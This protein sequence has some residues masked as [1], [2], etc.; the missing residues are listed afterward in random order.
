MAQ[1]N[2]AHPLQAAGSG[3]APAA[4]VLVDR[5]DGDGARRGAKFS[6]DGSE[7]KIEDASLG[8]LHKGDHSDHQSIT[9]RAGQ[10]RPGSSTAVGPTSTESL[11]SVGARDSEGVSHDSTLDVA[12]ADDTSLL[13]GISA[14]DLNGVQAGNSSGFA[15]IY[16]HTARALASLAGSAAAGVSTLLHRVL[17]SDVNGV[18]ARAAPVL[19]SS[20]DTGDVPH[21]P[22]I[23]PTD[24]VPT[25]PDDSEGLT[26]G[27][28]PTLPTNNG[29]ATPG[30]GATVPDI[31]P[32]FPGEEI[33]VPVV[34]AP[35]D[36]APNPPT[37]SLPTIEP[38]VGGGVTTP[39]DTAPEPP[40]NSAPSTPGDGATV[41]D[42]MPGFPG[43]EI[44]VPVVPVPIDVVPN[45]P[46]DSSP[47]I[48]PPAGGGVTTPVDVPPE[49]PSEI[50]TPV[51][52]PP[53]EAVPIPS[54]GIAPLPEVELT[55]RED[56]DVTL[57]VD[58]TPD[59]PAEGIESPSGCLPDEGPSAP[60]DVLPVVENLLL[61]A[62][63]LSVSIATGF[64]N[65]AIP[66]D[67]VAVGLQA[68]G[69][70]TL[71]VTIA[72]LPEDAI[73]SAG[74]ANSDGTWTLSGDELVGLTL[75]PAPDASDD[76]TLVVTATLQDT[77]TGATASAVVDL[78]VDI[79]AALPPAGETQAVELPALTAPAIEVSAAVGAE[80]TDIPLTISVGLLDL[81]VS[82]ELMITVSGLPTGASLS[83]GVVNTDGSWTLTR[84][85]LVELS[86][87]PAPDSDEDFTLA[88][89][90][91]VR[92][93]V[94]GAE[95]HVSATLPVEV[96]EAIGA[97]V[98]TPMLQAPSLAISA[99]VGIEN[100][101]VALSIATSLPDTSSATIL[102]VTI[103]GL[104]A[105]ANLSAGVQNA[106]G[107]WTLNGDELAGLTLSPA[108]D[109]DEDFTLN[110]TAT[111]RD[112]V[113]GLEAS[114]KV[115]LPVEIVDTSPAM[116][117]PV[118]AAPS[119]SVDAAAG[120][121]NGVI[122]L[123]ISA[124]IADVS[125][126]IDLTVVISGFPNGATLSA[127]RQGVDGT[128][129]LTSDQ[130]A[131]LTLTPAPDSGEDFTLT[132]VATARD[133]LTGIE[134]RTA[135]DLAVE[136]VDIE[137]PVLKIPAIAAPTLSVSAA[138]GAENG[139]IPLSISTGL[140]EVDAAASLTVVISGLPEGATL[141]TG[142]ANP[143]GSW[144]L[145]GDELAGL[146]LMPAPDS[147]E[148]FTLTVT[149]TARDAITGEE[150]RVTATLPVDV[151]ETSVP[152]E[153]KT[154]SVEIPAVTAPT[155]SVSAVVGIENE[156]VPLTISAALGEGRATSSLTVSI[157]GLP[158]GAVLS[159]GTQDADGTWLLDGG[160]L[161]GLTL[162]PAP[163]SDEDFTL[164]VTAT[165]RD[166]LTGL[167]ASTQ[168]T[169]P[170]EII[171][172]IVTS[173]EPTT[174]GE[175]P[176]ITA[177][178]LSVSAAA[179]LE[180]GTIPLAITVGAINAGAELEV[181][182]SGLPVGAAL[183][184]GVANA[185]GSWTVASDDLAGLTLTPAPD[186]GED[187]T[188]SVS[189]T[190]RDATSGIEA[191]TTAT[192]PVEVIDAIALTDPAPLFMLPIA[193]ALSVSAAMW[194][195]N[196]SIPLVI[197]VEVPSVT[198]STTL[199]V[200]VAGLPEGAT[201]SAGEQNADGTWNLSGDQLAGLTLTPAPNSSDDFAFS[202]TAT[203]YDALTGVAISTSAELTVD[204]IEALPPE[205]PS[206]MAPTL[207]VSVATG[208]ENGAIPLSIT[209]GLIDAASASTLT[210]TISG[211][212]EGATISAGTQSDDGTW[213][214]TGEEL[215]GL[216]LIPAA[217][218]DEDFT[219]SVGATV[220]DTFTGVE[221]TTSTTLAVEVLEAA[222]PAELPVIA[223]SQIEAPSLTI[224]AAAGVG[225]E[226]IP[227]TITASVA[228]LGSSDS[229][230]VAISGLPEGA[231]LSAGAQASDGTWLLDCGELAGLTLTPA[232]DSGEDFTLTVTAIVRDGLTG[233]QASTTATLPV[234]VIDAATPLSDAPA[235]QTPIV[236]PMLSV[237]AAVGAESDTIP[238]AISMGVFDAATGTLEITVSGLP[239]GATLS[240]GTP[241]ADGSWSLAGDDLAGLTLTPAPDSGEDFA[242]TVTATVRD[243]VTGTQASATAML[244]VE[245][246]DVV[247]PGEIAP[248]LGAPALMPTLSVSS[249]IGTADSE[250]P[251]AIALGPIAESA[252]GHLSALI[253]GVPEGATLSAGV[254]TPNG[255]WL[256]NGD[257]LAGLTLTPESGSTA[258]L[259]LIV[260]ATL[261]D[262]VTGT[263]ASAVAGLPVEIVDIAPQLAE[264]PPLVAPSLSVS[265]GIGV[266]NKAQP[267]II[268]ASSPDAIDPG[269]LTI[270]IGG[271]PET[272]VLSAG[273]ANAD[274]TWTL[275]AE[276]ISGLTLTPGSD[277]D[278]ILT[279]T[280]TVRD[281][282]TGL[283]AS[284]STMLAVDVADNFVAPDATSSLESPVLNEGIA[285]D[286]SLQATADTGTDVTGVVAAEAT[287]DTSS[288]SGITEV[289]GSSPLIETSEGGAIVESGALQTSDLPIEA[290]VAPLD[291][292]AA[293]DSLDA[294]MSDAEFL[295]A[296]ESLNGADSLLD[297]TQDAALTTSDALTSN[298]TAPAEGDPALVAE[299]IWGAEITTTT[300]PTVADE[301]V[302]P[303][304][305][306]T[307]VSVV[308]FHPGL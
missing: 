287:V 38:P 80:N 7:Q 21:P 200:T 264:L 168:V 109:S 166:A 262:P 302:A 263:E 16:Q 196:G 31:L 35:I 266:A 250:I 210:I 219:L 70:M 65:T 87:S 18:R 298:T 107:T 295:Q 29:A 252:G 55:L 202:V 43:E 158:I 286:T 45:P 271:M 95:A 283:E 46:T 277:A 137:A 199:T 63:T 289:T 9:H 33:E 91:S 232:A 292:T 208:L 192:L 267:L 58:T 249:A 223:P 261:I 51:V 230:T 2:K 24:A 108:P 260:T 227:L 299:D 5:Q 239:E 106:D 136:I 53:L 213:V 160:N 170:V 164:T 120:S 37:D 139:A 212:P 253:V 209:A 77:I 279:V 278:F 214:L 99:A 281:A 195:E 140:S 207:S 254:G 50:E 204:V 52:E 42:I 119:L 187:F 215:V 74:V 82:Q 156:T 155:L 183:S 221:A 123:V 275:T 133:R 145:S 206:L 305:E 257:E 241:N 197:L 62:P 235:T 231:T 90:A 83:A 224:S 25:P 71:N 6:G 307:L 129:L 15:S 118:F 101:T 280:A 180:D 189:A 40:T 244:P 138:V 4:N 222:P 301:P 242:L 93:L 96:I 76:F 191:T 291:T 144:S 229:L 270:M 179:G 259:T 54:T 64:E 185:D 186:S 56:N 68:A 238:L 105:G 86:L 255:T 181:T 132:V 182:I 190:I 243:A 17:D 36:V 127:G 188:L 153:T 184:A 171:D 126:A 293:T 159:A 113:T 169:L 304:P 97:P 12:L 149:A 217:D 49:L 88:V 104:P 59:L 268:T 85:D 112:G 152:I 225:N 79:I 30:D 308:V 28:G 177:P 19:P 273:T 248:D 161:A 233:A 303:P 173:L 246:V 39:V 272:A 237:S 34:P 201:L 125:G 1:Q 220:R 114:S 102:T 157:S 94:T 60:V 290:V 13:G 165:V 276:E 20:D 47:A 110:V 98:E 154:P 111:V 72:G 178:S 151:V 288:G 175:F 69:P 198:S 282:L 67:I 27:A 92:D 22:P 11:A 78:P 103:D 167:Q 147:D 143:D 84:S 81:D 10:A 8:H 226:A 296:I 130:L 256:L 26:P 176:P 300:E 124:G 245:V 247:A 163:D 174:G 23:L 236:A 284:S 162:T 251:L 116:E 73:L 14:Y 205:L 228:E 117:L 274:G 41:P 75:T 57:P 66:L 218:S 265:A 32:G 146:T 297:A 306:E 234:E 172:G 193:P 115:E 150:A 148:D 285:V 216:N 100:G 121:E 294:D 240:A 142:V 211:L 122:P 194:Q 135:V 269:V 131:G 3:A 128:W 89:T 134:T 141:S 203:I 61:V 258:D 44:E 48:E